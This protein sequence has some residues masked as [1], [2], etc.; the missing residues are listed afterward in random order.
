MKVDMNDLPTFSLV[1]VFHKQNA[2]WFTTS[3]L[4]DLGL[5][6]INVFAALRVPKQASDFQS[7]DSVSKT[8]DSESHRLSG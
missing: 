2:D 7:S 6:G 8:H 4:F 1:W 3:S 5:A